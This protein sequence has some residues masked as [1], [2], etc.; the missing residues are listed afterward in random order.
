MRNTQFDDTAKG[1]MLGIFAFILVFSAIPTPIAK[2]ASAPYFSMTLIAPTSNPVRRQW[3]QIVQN[4]FVSAGI[5]AHLVY[6]AFGQWLGLLLGNTTCPGGTTSPISGGRNCPEPPF[7]QGGWD[8][9][10]VGNGG[11]TVLPDFATQNVVFYRG[12]NPNFYPPNG[13]NDYWWRNSTYDGLANQYGN[14]FDT[15][16]RLPIAQKMVQIVAQERPGIVLLYPENLY[17]FNPNFK[18]WGTAGTAVTSSTAGLDWQ[19]WATGSTTTLNVALTGDL[20][21]VNPLPNGAQNS[22]YDR[23]MWGP[24]NSGTGTQETDARGTGVYINGVATSITSSAD[25]LTYTEN[26]IAHNFQDSVPVTADDY[27]FTTMAQSITAVGWVGSGTLATQ[28]GTSEEFHFLNGTVDY[29]KAGVYQH[30]G[31]APSGWTASSIWTSLS[32]TSF[33]F[34]LPAA[35]LFANPLITTVNVL[36]M[37]ALEHVSWAKWTSSPF[38]GFTSGCT[39][40]ADWS[41]CSTGG[42]SNHNFKVTWNTATFGGNGSFIAYGPIGDGPYVYRGYD[43]VTQTAT[44]V[45]FGGFW[46]ATGLASLHQFTLD[47]IHIQHIAGKDAAI[48]AYGTSAGSIGFMDTNYQFTKDDAAALNGLG[49]H[50]AYV[51]DPANGWQE[52]PLNDANPIWGLGTATPLGQATPAKAA[53]AAKQVRTAFSLL[54]PRTQIVNILV[55]GLASPGITQFFPT[56]GIV[57]A[58]DIYQGIS[59][60]PYDQ[61]KALSYLAAAGYNT[62]VAPPSQ[63][64]QIFP[65]TPITVSNI[66][67]NVPNFFVGNS[68]TLTGGFPLIPSPIVGAYYVTLQRSLDGGTTW[69]PVVLGTVS[70]GGAYS[71]S[72]TPLNTGNQWYRVFFSGVAVSYLNGSAGP[73]R[74]L[75]VPGPSLVE[76]YAP[77]QATHACSHALATRSGTC[78]ANSTDTQVTTATSL[79]VGS[80]SDLFGQLAT[81]LNGAFNGLK[82]S[83]NAAIATLNTNIGTVNTGL[84]NLQSTSAKQSDLTSLSGRLDTLNSQVSTLTTVAYAALAVAVILGLLAI[85]LS[86][87]KPS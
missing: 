8:V 83:T 72:Y 61:T 73:L 59:V 32:K 43:A 71:I 37:H 82:T 58:G 7:A 2:A 64:G 34:T 77:P 79:N 24:A 13:Q 20:D 85:A 57:H 31:S 26:F 55:Q 6:M 14:T 21:S 35:N 86:R 81:G 74:T 5:D 22:L 4:S 45:K 56:A 12:D 1:I 49:A 28:L 9:G 65:I 67:L 25:H 40:G 18:P 51:N 48:A 50:V 44:L 87:R 16:A 54:V 17:A 41:T 3:A 29:V 69:A 46:N 53:W 36:P 10:F 66:T 19:H 76:S 47:T 11:G 80:Y 42:I 30:G 33:S 84:N 38:S 39:N 23:Y 75:A 62:G 63:G 60:D 27:V 52:M 68:F 15:A 78:A 70:A